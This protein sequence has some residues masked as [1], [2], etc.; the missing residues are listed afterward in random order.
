[1]EYCVTTVST[2]GMLPE[3]FWQNQEGFVEFPTNLQAEEMS[4][5]IDT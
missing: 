3:E 1:M 2:A 5:M 4:Q